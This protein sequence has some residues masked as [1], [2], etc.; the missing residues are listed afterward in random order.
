MNKIMIVDDTRALT[1]LYCNFLNKLGYE[2][3]VAYD[4]LECLEVL[5]SKT[6][7]LIFLDIIM[8]P[9]DGWKTLQIIKK[10]PV[11]KKIPV[12]M[13]T[14]KAPVPG[15]FMNY[16]TLL[17]GY[18]MKPVKPSEL[19]DIIKMVFG[20]RKKAA[21]SAALLREAGLCEE[22]QRRFSELLI[23]QDVLF[24]LKDLICDTYSPQVSGMDFRDM[25]E[26]EL[27]PVF[28]I[29]EEN[30]QEISSLKDKIGLN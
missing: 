7:D 16:G 18:V 10:N 2:S 8:E 24:S 1:N 19:E 6:P 26:A 30:Q 4:G 23:Q 14:A 15:D 9:I 5:A 11:T 20:R 27:D 22:K 12:V 29:L 25:F 17:E 28:S 21:E 3:L 13:M